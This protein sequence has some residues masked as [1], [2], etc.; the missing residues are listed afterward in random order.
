MKKLVVINADDLGFSKGTNRGIIEAYRRGLLKS[1]SIMPTGPSYKEAVGMIKKYPGLGIG[2]HL[3]LTLGKAI[4]PKNKIP[5]LVDNKGYFYSNSVILLLKTL[6]FPR[7]LPQIKAELTG[8]IDTVLKNGI[9]IDHL[10]S[11]YQV[12]FMPQLFPIV[13]NLAKEYKIPFVRVPIEPLFLPQ[14]SLGLL[15]WLLMRIFGLIL[16]LQQKLPRE[17]PIFYGILHTRNMDVIT[18]TKT[19][20]CC[21]KGITE[22]LLHPGYFDLGKTHFNFSRQGIIGF[23]KSPNRLMEL[24]TLTTP[25]LKHLVGKYKL[26]LV[27]FGE[28]AEILGLKL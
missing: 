25:I 4:F 6:L 5:D 2:V 7:V 17:Y 11:Q 23:L 26:S 24:N 15:K 1:A 16:T 28:A 10:N 27:S 22:I 13:N 12:H 18:L 9:T 21:K 3:S 8:Q 20:S 19:L 14:F